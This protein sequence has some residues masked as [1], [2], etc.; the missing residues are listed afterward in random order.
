MAAWLAP[1]V[2]TVARAVVRRPRR[3]PVRGEILVEPGR[4]VGPDDVI[5]R[6]SSEQNLHVLKLEVERG[7]L[8]ATLL[9]QVGDPVRRGE[10]VA[11]STYLFG[12]G[13]R[14]YV[15]PVDGTVV[16]IQ[17][18]NGFF[19]IRQ[20]PT[21]VRAL[22]AGTVALVWP[23]EGVLLETIGAV[24]EGTAG[25]GDPTWGRLHP[26]AETGDGRQALA[27]GHLGPQVRGRVVVART[28]P[29]DHSLV[30]AVR[31]GARGAV[32]GSVDR[33][34]LRGFARLMTGL[35]RE[36]LEARYY[37]PAPEGDAGSGAGTARDS[38]GG[39]PVTFTL[40]ATEG[41][42]RVPMREEAWALLL[43]AAGRPAYLDGR[44][45]IRGQAG[46]PEVVVPDPE[47]TDADP[48]TEESG[49][50]GATAAAVQDAGQQAMARLAEG[51]RVRLI[52][53]TRF[54][55][56]GRLLSLPSEP[57]ALETG[58]QVPAARVALDTGEEVTVPWQNLEVMVH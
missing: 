19:V 2:L 29:D 31:F 35:S 58:R 15:A 40:V 7:E 26:V 25:F 38:A 42:G 55:A 6:D 33:W 8:Q 22:L 37:T 9:K 10:P 4:R 46:R 28:W 18:R 21:A 39:E 41:F 49:R 23:G 51:A 50:P 11:Y 27:P 34:L 57:L 47:V 3:L 36:E 17:P 24:V 5:G 14:E 12:L 43:R 45:R 30:Q 52:G 54:G 53:K 20:P 56:T 48:V 16:E 1:G 13:Y 44:V 32:V